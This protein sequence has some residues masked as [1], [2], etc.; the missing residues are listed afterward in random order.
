MNNR[1]LRGDLTPAECKSLVHAWHEAARLGRPLN[2]LVSIRPAGEL[3]PIEHAKLVE[4]FWD[5]LAGW[6]RY[7]SGDF[8]MCEGKAFKA[9][10]ARWF[11]EGLEA[12]VR[13]SNQNEG[14]SAGGKCRSA[15]GYLTKQ[16]TPQAT[17]RTPYSRER[18]GLVL[19][20]RYKISRSLRAKQGDV[21]TLPVALRYPRAA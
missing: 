4:K 18:G 15:I 10:V 11:P 13:P 16:R 7:H 3:T 19:G 17:Y 9:A 12:D 6:C 14:W 20:Q 2:R 21:S 1:K 5:K 8:P